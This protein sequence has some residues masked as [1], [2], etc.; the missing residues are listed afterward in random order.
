[1]NDQ[2]NREHV[3]HVVVP[4]FLFDNFLVPSFSLSL[5]FLWRLHPP[6]YIFSYL[7]W[8]R[9][10]HV[11]LIICNN[12]KSHFNHCLDVLCILESLITISQIFFDLCRFDKTNLKFV[13]CPCLLC[14]TQPKV[15]LPSIICPTIKN[16]LNYI[17]QTYRQV[18]H[19]SN[20][21]NI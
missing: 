20:Q 6:N 7:P 1:M 2:R 5:H 16:P 14:W 12:N 13:M 9:R 10:V 8:R 21:L 18:R 17:R 15:T 3:C 19:K 11:N 4:S